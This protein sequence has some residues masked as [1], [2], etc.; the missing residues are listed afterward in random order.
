MPVRKAA[1]EI[2]LELDRPAA[3]VPRSIRILRRK[4]ILDTAPVGTIRY[5]QPGGFMQNSERFARCEGI[6]RKMWSA[7]PASVF[8]L[9]REQLAGTVV[10]YTAGRPAPIQTR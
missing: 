4:Q 2:R 1:F 5:R 10:D 3:H 6:A 7:R 9:E 8:M